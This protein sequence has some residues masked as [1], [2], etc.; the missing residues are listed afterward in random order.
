MTDIATLGLAINSAP[1]TQASA[2]L[3]AFQ[4]SA[5]IAADAA[6]KLT[7]AAKPA[8]SSTATLD[9]AA[10]A[11][12]GSSNDLAKS[13]GGLSSQA[14]SA[15]HAVR[16][17]IEQ[18]SLGA[19]PTQILTNQLGH[20][21]Y[22]ASG[23]GG[24]TGAFKEAG[25]A[26]LGL[27]NPAVLVGAAAVAIG[28]GFALA[29]NSIV[30]SGKAF[31]DVSHSAGTAMDTLQG[32]ARVAGSDGIG[33]ADFLKAYGKFAGDVY[34]ANH[35]LGQLGDLLH[36]N[37]QSAGS[38]ASAFGKV[39]DLIK[40]SSSD[41]QRLQLLQQAGLP[42]T[43]EWVRLMQQGSDGIAAAT[44]NFI[45]MNPEQQ[46][47]VDQARE[48]D[49]AW[50]SVI[51]N[52]ST[53]FKNAVLSGVSAMSQLGPAIQNLYL[54]LGADPRGILKSAMVAGDQGLD[55]GSDVSKFYSGLGSG[56][57]GNAPKPTPVDPQAAMR[58]DRKSVV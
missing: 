29:V 40:N 22:A 58:A 31:D 57:P 48:F 4:K 51:A 55:A 13:H 11:A 26:L 23:P 46:K 8:A 6:D 16:S 42:A 25:G 18:I 41:Q 19:P 39:A 36:A 49:K 52:I 14:M 43:M 37:G 50:S 53:G 27:I 5:N 12:T 54:K 2:A 15:Q 28:A 44:K 34:D 35:A 24:I 47:L 10:A 32:L 45:Q 56:A 38:T 30:Q 3:D 21:S 9:K 1:V 20:L 7:E 17:M 33:S